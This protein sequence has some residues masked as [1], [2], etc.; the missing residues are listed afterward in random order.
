[1]NIT[2][3]GAGNVAWHLAQALDSAGHTVQ[4][5]Y[6]RR[7]QSAVQLAD[8]LYNAEPT[9]SLDFSRSK[10]NVFFI[11]VPDQAIASLVTRLQLPVHAILVHT[12]GT[13]PIELLSAF[14]NTG[15]FYPL[16]TFSKAK[17]L[18]MQQVPF[19]I[20][21]SNPETEEV[22]VSLAQDISRTVYLVSS[23]ERKVLHVAAVFACNFTNHLLSIA[24]QITLQENLEF[25]LLEPLIRETINK[26]LAGENPAS[27][28]TGPAVRNDTSTMQSH[29]DYLSRSPAEKEIYQL[30]SQN[31]QKVSREL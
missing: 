2:F 3:I 12:S 15:V 22:L 9:Q 26:A 8:Q 5:V 4:Q 20:E 31:I 30:I 21:A 16:Q 18:Q 24:Y 27:V 23:A 10:A 14:E 25:S 19:C 13:L 1:M 29:L 6:S 11:A 17:A 7:L 28:Q